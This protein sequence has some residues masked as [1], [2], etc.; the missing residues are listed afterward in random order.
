MDTNESIKKIIDLYEGKKY[1]EVFKLCN[2]IKKKLYDVKILAQVFSI[3][4]IQTKK[5]NDAESFLQRYISGRS[6]DY[7][8][9][10]NLGLAQLNLG[11]YHSAI[12]TFE[13]IL[14][15]F[16]KSFHALNNLG[17]CLIKVNDLK[18]AYAALRKSISINDKFPLSHF[19]IGNVLE[20]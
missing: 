19:N 1:D 6:F 14:G 8:I 10:M 12:N 2:L 15:E 13:K 9:Y 16:P 5:Y 11:K 3:S 18:G 20:R 7:D 4:C 17:N